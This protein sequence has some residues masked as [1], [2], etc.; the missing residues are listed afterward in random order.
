MTKLKKVK[1]KLPTYWR[2]KCVADAKDKAKIRDNYV[3]QICGLREPEI[4]EIHHIKPKSKFPELM[5]DLENMIT[6]CP[7]CHRR[8][9]VREKAFD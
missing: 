6:L 7:N 1:K 3:C 8:K 9:S 4:M 2:K 5:N